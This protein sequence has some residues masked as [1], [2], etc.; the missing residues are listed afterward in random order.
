MHIIIAADSFKGTL[1]SLEAGNVIKEAALSVFP[2]SSIE[3][4]P[5]ADGGE[6]TVEAVLHC[7][8]GE[9]AVFT[10]TGPLGEPVQASYG[11][12]SGNRA[13]MEMAE[14]SGLMLVPKEKRNPLLTSTM[15]TGEMIARAMEDGARKI[16]LGIGGSATCD[17]G[18]GAMEALGFRFLDKEG[19]ELPGR[20]ASLSLVDRIDLSSCHPLLRETDLVVLSD[21]KNPLCGVRGAALAFAP[22]KGADEVMAEELERGMVHY[23]ELLKKTFGR[24]PD[25]IPGSGAAGGL[26]AA[27]SLF[28][29][30]SMVSGAEELL[31]LSCFDEKIQKADLV[32]TGEGR[33]DAQSG[34]GKITGSI[35][36]HCARCSVPCAVL[37]GSLGKGWE[38]LRQQGAL[39]VYGA[40]WGEEIEKAMKEPAAYLKK[41]AETFF[42]TWQESGE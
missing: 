4:L 13:I 39:A 1:S 29:G 28:L 27:L 11:R 35:V 12:L 15:G 40:A 30:A 3:V 21:V 16:F 6:G 9:K 2:G 36:K 14:A 19:K 18:M 26:G 17:G 32:I 37:S 24:N 8:A 34:E 41:A 10:V 7:T 25:D 23:R 22:Q 31:G 38:I 33:S 42:K 5:M 20:G